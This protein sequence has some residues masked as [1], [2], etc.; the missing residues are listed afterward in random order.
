MNRLFLIESAIAI[1]V[2]CELL[3]QNSERWRRDG[4]IRTAQDVRISGRP[5]KIKKQGVSKGPRS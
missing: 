4:V 1:R 3:R 5:A 2:Q